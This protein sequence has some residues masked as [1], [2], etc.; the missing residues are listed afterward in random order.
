MQT[1]SRAF[2]TVHLGVHYVVS[3]RP[4]G[5]WREKVPKLI[6][7]INETSFWGDCKILA[8]YCSNVLTMPIRRLVQTVAPCA[9][10]S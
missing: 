6:I 8:C 5:L 7:F 10:S 3:T 1:V 4:R 2:V 9:F